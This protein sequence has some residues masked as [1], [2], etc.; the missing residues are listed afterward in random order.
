VQ[1]LTELSLPTCL[2]L[3]KSNVCL[4]SQ[5]SSL[6][7]LSA[8]VGCVGVLLLLP[9]LSL[10]DAL[11]LSLSRQRVVVFSHL[12]DVLRPLQLSADA[13]LSLG[14]FC[15]LLT[16]LRLTN[17]NCMWANAQTIWQGVR[18]LSPVRVQA[19]DYLYVSF[20]LVALLF[21]FFFFFF[22]KV[23][24]EVSPET[25]QAVCCLTN[26]KSLRLGAYHDSPLSSPFPVAEVRL[27][28]RCCD[29][30]SVLSKAQAQSSYRFSILL[31]PPLFSAACLFECAY[32][33]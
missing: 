21:F 32:Q 30:R 17:E 26:L 24:P 4:V 12:F 22:F 2:P 16:S 31:A 18:L 3:V 5:L 8:S 20:V 23:S 9:M 11:S 6:R 1:T 27:L 15:P 10:V 28:D 14:A 13:I 19:V 7:K 33:P 29:F 25:L